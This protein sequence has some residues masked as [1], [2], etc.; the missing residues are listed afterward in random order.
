MDI[1]V[2]RLSKMT[3]VFQL[4][5]HSVG[6]CTASSWLQI[7]IFFKARQARYLSQF[8]PYPVFLLVKYFKHQ[9]MTL[10]KCLY[11]L[12]WSRLCFICHLTITEFLLCSS[13]YCVLNTKDHSVNKR[14]T[15]PIPLGSYFHPSGDMY[16]KH[17][18]SPSRTAWLLR[19]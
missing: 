18:D 13:F 11:I 1:L 19:V 17:H 9:C 2:L 12:Y 15:F 7:Q 8:F 16:W 4:A 3:M 6:S 14:N 5:W 10:F